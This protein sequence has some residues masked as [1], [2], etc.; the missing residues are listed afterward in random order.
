MVKKLMVCGNDYYT[1][2]NS[3]YSHIGINLIFTLK[4][5]LGE[6]GNKPHASW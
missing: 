3:A 1:H 4:R 5:F 2:G 6:Y